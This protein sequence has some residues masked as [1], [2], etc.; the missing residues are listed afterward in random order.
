MADHLDDDTIAAFRETFDAIDSDKSGGINASEL[1]A[2]LKNMFGEHITNAEVMESMQ[3][4]DSDGDGT[5]TFQEFLALCSD[6][7]LQTDASQFVDIA[8]HTFD[9]DGDGKI[10]PEDLLACYREIGDPAA[11][12]D[13][14]KCLID[15][16]ASDH[17]S[18]TKDE[19]TAWMN[20]P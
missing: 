19:F 11:T 15:F 2:L 1:Q 18:L 6:K 14:A 7:M 8:Y 5:I 13:E 3:S 12:M 20:N 17:K 10:G 16:F 4:I 9:K